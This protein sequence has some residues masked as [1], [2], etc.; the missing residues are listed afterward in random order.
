MKKEINNW[1]RECVACQRAKVTKQHVAS[2]VAIDIPKRRFTHVHVDIVGPLP[3]AENGETYLFTMIDRTSRWIEAAPLKEMTAAACM[4]AFVSTWVARFGDPA[5]LTSDRGTQFTSHVWADL[6]AKLGMVHSTTTAYH[7]QANGMVERAHRQIKDGLRAR[8][9]GADWPTHLPWLLLG[10]R[11]APKEVSN[12]SSAEAVYGQ[13]LVLPGEWPQGTEA[14]PTEFA[15]RLASSSP[16]PTVLPRTW[17][18]VAAPT[19]SQQLQSCK[20]VFVKKGGSLAPL[21]SNY[22][23]PYE[24]VKHGLKYFIVKIGDKDDTVSV[25]RLKPYLGSAVPEA[26]RP[27]TRGRPPKASAAC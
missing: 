11:A 6:C 21:A 20:Y 2:P 4:K 23:G 10:L 14:G 26:V 13:P 1:C 19:H 18:E 22:D 7:P 5:T 8:R 9:A 12:L 25:D 15:E 24:V 27:P 3:V 17:A 16:P